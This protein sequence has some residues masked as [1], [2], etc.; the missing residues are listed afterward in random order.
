MSSDAEKTP[1]L[2]MWPVG[3][4]PEYIAARI[5]LAK[6]E[7]VLRD[8]VEQVAA[9]RRMLPEGAVLPDYVLQEGP[10][11]PNVDEPVRTTRLVEIF[12]EHDTLFVYHLMFHPNEDEA[13]PMCSM[14]VDGLHG[15]SA[16]LARHTAFAVIGKAQLPKLRAWARL[17][18]WYGLRILSSH[19]TTF[20]ADMHAELPDGTQRPMVSVFIK[21]GERV[22][23]YYTL[24][25]NFLDNTERGIDLLSPVWN[26][27]D[28]LPAGRRDWY[29]DNAYIGRDGG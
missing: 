3:S 19:G 5:D 14:W 13:C 8:Q 12:G 27:L 2:P 17:R 9:A 6:A 7:L 26:V 23:H 25:A 16:H 15:V 18:G 21:A 28:L 4:S 24:P 29:A 22:R 1:I 11:D 10:P 20:N